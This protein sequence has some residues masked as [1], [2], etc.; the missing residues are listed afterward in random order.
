[1][2]DVK[3][4]KSNLDQQIPIYIHIFDNILRYKSGIKLRNGGTYLLRNS[5]GKD[6]REEEHVP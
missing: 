1:M 4:Q 3:S 5:H 6:I 2:Q